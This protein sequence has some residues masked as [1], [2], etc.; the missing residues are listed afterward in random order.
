MAQIGRVFVNFRRVTSDVKSEIDEAIRKAE[1][2]ILLQERTKIQKLL[3]DNQA[4]AVAEVKV[5]Q[6]QIQS[7]GSEARESEPINIYDP[8]RAPWEE[9]TPSTQTEGNPKT[10]L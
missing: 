10:S 6:D 2:D 8:N 4:K 3:E 7:L 5:V 1:N 9:S